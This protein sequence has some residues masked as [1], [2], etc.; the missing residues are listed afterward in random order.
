MSVEFLHAHFAIPDEISYLNGLERIFIKLGDARKRHP[1]GLHT[2][3]VLEDDYD[4]LQWAYCSRSI[5]PIRVLYQSFQDF[6]PCASLQSVKV[7]FENLKI[8]L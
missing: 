8:T 6:M 7:A 4:V 3:Y 1:F 2:P 5:P